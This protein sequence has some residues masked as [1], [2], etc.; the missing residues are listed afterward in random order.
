MEWNAQGPTIVAQA[1][2]SEITRPQDT[3]LCTGTELTNGTG[4]VAPHDDDQGES[5]IFFLSLDLV[6]R[7]RGPYDLVLPPQCFECDLSTNWIRL[8]WFWLRQSGNS[9]F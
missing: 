1:D 5:R 8:S 3:K 7:S 6:R 9:G 2:N 4:K